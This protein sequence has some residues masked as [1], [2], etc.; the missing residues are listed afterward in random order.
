M[1]DT[2]SSKR[3]FRRKRVLEEEGSEDET[4]GES[5]RL[6]RKHFCLVFQQWGFFLTLPRHVLRRNNLEDVRLLQKSR[7]RQRGLV[8]DAEHIT[9]VQAVTEKQGN[10]AGAAEEGAEELVLQDTFAQETA[11]HVEDPNM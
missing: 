11:V 5:F 8:V 2:V 9:T 4:E 3:H 7:R 10:D 1:A 6:E